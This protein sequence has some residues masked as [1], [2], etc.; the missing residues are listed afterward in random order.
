MV[1][2]LNAF[3]PDWVSPPGATIAS[4]LSQKNL[5]VADFADELGQPSEWI[6]ALIAGNQRITNDLAEQLSATLGASTSFW[7]QRE[8]DFRQE[9]QVHAAIRSEQDWIG[10]L[11]VRQMI[12]FGWLPD[13]RTAPEKVRNCLAFFGVGSISEWQAKYSG[14]LSAAAFRSSDSFKQQPEA[15]AAWLRKGELEADAMTCNS[16]DAE[17][18]RASLPAI[19]RLTLLRDP[20]VFL[21]QLQEICSRSGVAVVIVRPPTGCRA[22]GATRF[23]ADDKAMILLSFRHKTDDHFWFTFFHEAGHLLMHTD[24]AIFI[25]GLTEITTD[26]EDEADQFAQDILIPEAFRD[27][28]QNLLPRYKDVL[29]FAVKV[30]ITPGIPSPLSN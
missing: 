29:R 10:Q 6:E 19:R 26:E 12:N 11:P 24:D 7:L 5:T 4:L 20:Q 23:I 27:E 14:A 21:P 17:S 1:A 8:A 18:F 25:E 13:A 9:A 15:V 22:S 2:A 28:L 30:G 3:R 16:W